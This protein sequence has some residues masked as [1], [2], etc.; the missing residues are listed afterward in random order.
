[1]IAPITGWKPVPPVAAGTAYCIKIAAKVEKAIEFKVRRELQPWRIESSSAWLLAEPSS[2]E[3]GPESSMR[4]KITAQPNGKEGAVHDSTLT[5]T[6]AGGAV[7]E[8]YKIRTYVIPPYQRPAVPAGEAVYLNDLDQKLMTWHVEAGFSKDTKGFRPWFISPNPTPNYKRR[9]EQPTT[10][11]TPY[12]MGSKTFSRGLWVSPC[13]ETIYRVEGA[14][15][16]AFAAQVGFYDGLAKR[17]YA[18]LG[19]VVN[20]EIYVDGTLRTQSGPMRFGD[21]PRLLAA[22]RL[23]GAR[24]VKL[25]TRRDDLVND[26]YCLA[27]WGDPRFYRRR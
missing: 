20:F 21:A 8:D 24:E 27:T 23:E 7:K 13:H 18:N 1:V 9:E 26:W 2:G 22:D 11:T 3:I 14:G 16:A 25:V 4:V 6:A 5:L 15:F 12:T 17:A 19:A 10:P